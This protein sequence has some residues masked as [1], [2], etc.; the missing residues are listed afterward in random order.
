VPNYRLF[1]SLAHAGAIR[2][3]FSNFFL[4]GLFAKYIEVVVPSNTSRTINS[5]ESL[6]SK[7]LS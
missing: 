5:T 3:P 4:P 7:D 2:D 6:P 1:T